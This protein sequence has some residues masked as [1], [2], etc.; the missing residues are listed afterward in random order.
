MHAFSNSVALVTGATSGIGR[1]VAM[2]FAREGA[3]VIVSGRREHA[4]QETVTLIQQA[5]GKA[6]FVQADVTRES[7]VAAL[8]ETL[9][10]PTAG[11][12]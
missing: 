6:T 11:S 9:C 8:V 5:G 2:A 1:A 4:G 7:E 3:R 12:T 10:P